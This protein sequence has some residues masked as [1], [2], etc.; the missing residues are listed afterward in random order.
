MIATL[1]TNPVPMGG[2]NLWLVLPVCAVAAVVYK[3]IRVKHL[4]KLPL[5]ILG[6]WAYM[7]I[8]LVVLGAAFYL[9]LQYVA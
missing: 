9:L 4:R 1:C 6:L 2:E 5:Q 8:G 7:F 3:T